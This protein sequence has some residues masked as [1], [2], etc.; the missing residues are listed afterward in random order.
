VIDG[1]ITTRGKVFVPPESPALPGLLAH[2][3]GCG[4]EGTKKTLHR[5]RA[6]FHVPDAHAVV[7]NFVSACSIYQRN[8]TEQL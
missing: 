7:R 3:N 8:K 6:E 5:L 1:L 4:H 2:A